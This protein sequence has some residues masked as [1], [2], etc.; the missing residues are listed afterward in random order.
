MN[1]MANARIHTDTPPRLRTAKVGAHL[2]QRSRPVGKDSLADESVNIAKN[3]LTNLFN[4]LTVELVSS[5]T[6]LN[7]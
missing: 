2:T 3:L 4:L 5:G 6:I 7:E 1:E